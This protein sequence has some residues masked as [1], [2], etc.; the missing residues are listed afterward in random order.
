MPAVSI[1]TPTSGLTGTVG[2][3][4]SLTL[5]KSGGSGSGTFSIASGTLPAGLS[6]DGATGVISGTPTAGGTYAVT[7]RITDTNSTTATTTSFSFV[8]SKGTQ[9]AISLPVL[10]ATGKAFPYSQTP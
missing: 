8:I 4:Y 7:A 5:S 3:A 2:T 6:L 9:A 1:T 10:S